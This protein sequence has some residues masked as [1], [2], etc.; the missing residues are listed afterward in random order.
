M[1][2]IKALFNF[3]LGYFTLT[4]LVATLVCVVQYPVTRDNLE[5]PFRL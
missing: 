1:I 2:Y 5:I 3:C 4:A